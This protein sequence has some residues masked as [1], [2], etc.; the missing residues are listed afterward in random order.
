MIE[1]LHALGVNLRAMDSLAKEGIGIGDGDDPFV[2][3]AAY[4]LPIPV[5][6]ALAD[7]ATI[8]A[9]RSDDRW[10]LSGKAESTD[11]ELYSLDLNFT[12]LLIQEVDDAVRE[13]LDRDRARALKAAS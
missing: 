1:D 12:N 7:P 11:V 13:R 2:T 8:K 3:I 9:S 6:L 4:R 5:F 10:W